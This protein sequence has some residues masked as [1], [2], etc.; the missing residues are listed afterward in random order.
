[1]STAMTSNFIISTIF[2][3]S[4]SVCYATPDYQPLGKPATELGKQSEWNLTISPNGEN[5][6]AG[7]GL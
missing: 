3:L 4:T 1:M 6:P 7:K 2:L 5:L